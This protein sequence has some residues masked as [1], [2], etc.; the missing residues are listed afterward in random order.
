[1]SRPESP[2]LVVQPDTAF[3]LG[4]MV[5]SLPPWM[6]SFAG[7]IYDA[8]SHLYPEHTTQLL[9]LRLAQRRSQSHTLVGTFERPLASRPQQEEHA[10]WELRFR[11]RQHLALERPSFPDLAGGRSDLR[12]FPQ[13]SKWILALVFPHPSRGIPETLVR[14]DLRPEILPGQRV[15]FPPAGY[16]FKTLELIY[17]EIP[18]KRQDLQSVLYNLAEELA[19]KEI[20]SLHENPKLN[21]KIVDRLRFLGLAQEGKTD[22]EN[23]RIF[24][25]TLE[26]TLIER[27]SAKGVEIGDLRQFMQFA[28]VTDWVRAEV[29]GDGGKR[30]TGE[31]YYCHYLAS[32]WILW[33]REERHLP[34]PEQLERME[35]TEADLARQELAEAVEDV[36]GM[37]IHDIPEDL[38]QFMVSE[39]IFVGNQP[40]FRLSLNYSGIE[41]VE[42]QE[43]SILQI[44]KDGVRLTPNQWL[45][46]QAIT[47]DKQSDET[48]GWLTKIR[49]IK[50]ISGIDGARLLRRAARCKAADRFSNLLTMTA[51]GGPYSDVVRKLNETIDSGGQLLWISE[52]EDLPPM[53]VLERIRKFGQDDSLEFFLGAIPLMAQAEKTR[54][55]TRHGQDYYRRLVEM[56][57]DQKEPLELEEGYPLVKEL[58]ANIEKHVLVFDPKLYEALIARNKSRK[59]PWMKEPWVDYMIAEMRKVIRGGNGQFPPHLKRLCHLSA[60]YRPAEG[61][62]RNVIPASDFSRLIGLPQYMMQAKFENL[63]D[64]K[65][66]RRPMEFGDFEDYVR[67]LGRLLSSYETCYGILPGGID[68]FYVPLSKELE[69]DRVLLDLLKH[70]SNEIPGSTPR[71]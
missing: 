32:A 26:N 3:V 7:P 20:P 27:M 5:D 9:A 43:T 46:T 25:E 33:T 13:Y 18:E 63:V 47:R 54:L 19:E 49:R 59:A 44:L 23:E 52:F 21:K 51:A 30:K 14:P 40:F 62:L 1:M 29:S 10:R 36:K 38:L 37:F 41:A 68:D 57:Q 70:L 4:T 39:P 24:I 58:I 64:A 71:G 42:P 15:P 28:R 66:E 22:E 53:K 69:A 45:I 2:R 65:G 50:E 31:S 61:E 6:R 67:V 17:P 12:Y 60:C 56:A 48:I 55:L 35:P 8:A 11:T 34:N 16:D